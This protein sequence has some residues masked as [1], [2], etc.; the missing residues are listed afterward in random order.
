MSSMAYDHTMLPQFHHAMHVGPSPQY[1]VANACMAI[2]HRLWLWLSN[3]GML[4]T[5]IYP[6]K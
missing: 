1:L 6:V 3:N 5:G 2:L 4:P